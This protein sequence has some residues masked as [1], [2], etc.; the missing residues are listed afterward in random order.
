[1]A[2]NALLVDPSLFTAPYNAALNTGLN[3][4]GVTTLWATRGLREGEKADLP[5][6]QTAPIFYPGLE[7]SA[8]QAGAA[9][10][11]RKAI[12]HIGSLKRMIALSKSWPADIVHLQWSVLPAAD[13][14]AV[15]K[16]RQTAPVVLTVHDTTPF[17]GNP[18]SKLQVMGFP[19]V[20]AEVD[21]VI[22]HTSRGRDALTE[23]GCATHKLSVIPHG[24]F[25]LDL[26]QTKAHTPRD[27][28][29]TVVLFGRLQDY[30]GVDVLIDALAALP[31][32][33]RDALRV[34]IAGEPFCD[35]A[36]AQAK[37]AQENLNIDWHLGWLSDDDMATL[38]VEADALVFPYRRI[39]ASGVYYLTKSLGKWI[40]ASD[41]GAF[42][43]EITPD[44]G[45]LV[46][47]GDAD[48]LAQA[49]SQSIGK[50]PAPGSI[51]TDW[52]EIGQRT[53]ALY[54]R[55]IANR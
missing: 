49:L 36:P 9:A 52:P 17:N 2:I 3:A 27:P 53:A 35:L 11:L 6:A 10:K 1:M 19:Q 8:K 51:G 44:T 4:A 37:A 46:P 15:H 39:E 54:D 20:L 12:S 14:R 34:V 40:I 45:H 55:L 5:E 7:A 24:P 23:A 31:P 41:L 43:D 42:G 26:S 33:T 16:L 28:R 22:V 30:K 25:T 21:H 29:W 13:L 38:M 47:P 32:D 50:T 18:T 48:A